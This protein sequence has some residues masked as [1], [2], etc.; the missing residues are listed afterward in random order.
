MEQ[1]E[2]NILE[3]L[4][5]K[6]ESFELP[7]A[8][9]IWDAIEAEINEDPP[10]KRGGFWFVLF[11]L[12]SAIGMGLFFINS[13]NGNQLSKRKEKVNVV[14]L[15]KVQLGLDIGDA[16]GL[17][18]V[19]D[20]VENQ[21]ISQR[22]TSSK[23]NI[24]SGGV[25]I[26]VE[27]TPQFVVDNKRTEQASGHVLN[28]VYAG[29]KSVIEIED[30]SALVSQGNALISAI[31]EEK[32]T[33]RIDGITEKEKL[34]SIVVVQIENDSIIQTNTSNEIGLN[35]TSDVEEP[36]IKDENRQESK[37]GLML[38]G[39]V[40]SSFRFLKGNS[41]ADLISHKNDH[42]TYGNTYDF[43]IKLHCNLNARL[44]ARVGLHYKFYSDKYDFQHDLITHT[45]K[46]DYQYLQVPLTLGWRFFMTNRQ[47]L[48]FVGGA[49][50][51]RLYSA[52][53]SWVDP[54][55]LNPVAHNHEGSETPFRKST[56]GIIGKLD[57]QFKLNA[58][59]AVHLMPSVDVFTT[60]IY[61][62]VTDINQRPYA[63]N[64]DLGLTYQF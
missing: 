59:W 44:F 13:V 49:K 48:A 6:S 34:D 57:Y 50:W 1:E 56:I 40:G 21:L 7:V 60:S 61:K 24:E 32:D 51:N 11:G 16:Q 36:I 35:D 62:R 39:G 31:T 28:A 29:S 25:T 4:Q 9:N 33:D 52:Q 17:I 38:T 53:S 12:A 5:A 55:S 26:K 8:P 3:N 15:S 23:I 2:K 30:S 41:I 14:L 63:F 37:F 54:A 45:T 43:G 10:K 42:E 58:N 20:T 46:N 18:T 19:N 47:S 22:N 27:D 64:V